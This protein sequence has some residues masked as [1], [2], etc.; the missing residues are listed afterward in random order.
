MDVLLWDVVGE[1]RQGIRSLR[2]D[3]HGPDKPVL[4]RWHRPVYTIGPELTPSLLPIREGLLLGIKIPFREKVPQLLAMRPSQPIPAVHAV[5]RK[6][7][8]HRDRG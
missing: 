3:A 4:M 2:I 5:C 1:R 8:R 7:F 6:D